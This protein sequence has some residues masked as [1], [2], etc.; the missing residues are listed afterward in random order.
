[1]ALVDYGSDNATGTVIELCTD[2]FCPFDL[3]ADCIG[4]T[5]E[6]SSASDSQDSYFD[7]SDSDR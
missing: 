3:A 2:L 6:E 5:S 4:D 7:N 1:M